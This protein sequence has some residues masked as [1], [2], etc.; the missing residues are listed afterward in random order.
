MR[1]SVTQNIVFVPSNEYPKVIITRNQVATHTN[2]HTHIMIID[3]H[4]VINIV[5]GTPYQCHIVIPILV[6]LSHQ[7]N[8]HSVIRYS[9]LF[10]S[11]APIKNKYA[12]HQPANFDLTTD[13]NRCTVIMAMRGLLVCRTICLICQQFLTTEALIVSC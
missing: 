7:H 6:D 8:I 5:T 10:F 12:I 11:I 3:H 9:N 2:T 13:H 4:H 1:N